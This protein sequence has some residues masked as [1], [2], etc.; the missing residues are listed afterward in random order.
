MSLTRK[1][2]KSALKVVKKPK[3][4]ITLRVDKNC[5]LAQAGATAADFAMKN[6]MKSFAVQIGMQAE[7][8]DKEGNPVASDLEAGTVTLIVT[9]V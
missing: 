6:D 9:E 7:G 4:R 2:K 3:K 1:A 8:K 5:S